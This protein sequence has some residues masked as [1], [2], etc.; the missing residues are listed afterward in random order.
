MFQIRRVVK[1]EEA[2]QNAQPLKGEKRSVKVADSSLY[3]EKITS[4]G[5]G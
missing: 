4:W 3:K 1:H 5:Q 2:T